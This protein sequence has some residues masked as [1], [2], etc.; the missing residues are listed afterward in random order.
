MEWSY[1]KIKCP[2]PSDDGAFRLTVAGTGIVY[3]CTDLAKLLRIAAESVAK[4]NRITMGF[5]PW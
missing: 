3:E 2:P 4:G 5:V 1:R